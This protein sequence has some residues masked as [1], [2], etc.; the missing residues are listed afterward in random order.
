MRRTLFAGL[1]PCLV[2]ALAGCGGSGGATG[3]APD[4]TFAYDASA[5]LRYVDRGR[6]NRG[7]PI[8]VRD[9]SFAGPAGMPIAGY[10]ALPPGK[11]PYPAVVYLHGSG[12]DRTE[13][14]VPAVWLAGRGAVTLT[15]DAP[16]SPPSLGSG[17]E[18]ELRR[19]R[20]ATVEAVVAAR[21]AIDALQALPQVDDSRIALV[22]WSAGART[23]ALLAGVDR[24]VSAF[25]LV[26]GGSTPVAAYA[27][28]AP[29]SLRQAVTRELGAVDPLRLIAKAAPGTI[30]LQDGLGDEVVPRSALEALARA[31]GG[32]AEVRWYDAGHAPTEKEYREQLDWLQRKLG[33]SGPPVKG[34]RAGP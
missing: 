11:G 34:A 16:P 17:P 26:S 3:A 4:E 13:L 15:I 31:A 22:G 24:R 29:E 1:L 2:L 19:Q 5:P 23:G 6:V 28:E 25:A 32:A 21:R 27:A 9:I 12:G 10:L 33:I 18:D 7:Y 8:Q 20:Q 30:L 14:L